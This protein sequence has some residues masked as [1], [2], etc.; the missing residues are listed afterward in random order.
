V[1]LARGPVARQ[2]DKRYAVRR[3]VIGDSVLHHS[4]RR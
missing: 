2:I 3:N 1:R 4:L